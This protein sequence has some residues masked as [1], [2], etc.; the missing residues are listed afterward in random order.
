MLNVYV[1]NLG[2]Y[3]EG[4]L[5]GSWLELP[6][7]EEQMQETMVKIG[8]AT[9]KDGEFI[10]CKIEVEN[11]NEYCYEEYAVHDFETDIPGLEIGEYSNLET[12]NTLAEKFDNMQEYEGDQLKALLEGGYLYNKDIIEK[13]INDI[14]DQHTFINLDNSLLNDNTRLGIAIV[15]EIFCDDLKQIENLD[16]YFDYEKFASDLYFDFDTIV[17]DMEEEDKEELEKMTELEFLNWYIEGL[18]DIKELGSET[19]ENYF[20]YEKYGRDAS[21][22]GAF[23]SSNNIAIL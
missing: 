13:D 14:L 19:L 23:I 17:E 22:N 6:V 21:Y 16:F 3:N 8:V 7:T 10:P 2:K 18:G 4:E 15:E 20:S 11:G 1:A 5:V 9:I 12:L